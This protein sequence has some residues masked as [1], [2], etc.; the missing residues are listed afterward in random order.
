MEQNKK[1][2]TLKDFDIRFDPNDNTLLSSKVSDNNGNVNLFRLIID[3]NA[4]LIRQRI[5]NNERTIF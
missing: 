5:G 2:L 4:P 3:P 1:H